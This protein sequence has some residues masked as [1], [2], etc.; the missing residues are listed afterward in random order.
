LN[1]YRIEREPV[2]RGRL[3]DGR[4][5]FYGNIGEG[6]VT[7]GV[8][9]SERAVG[10]PAHEIDAIVKARIAGASKTDIKSLVDRLHAERAKIAEGLFRG[11][12]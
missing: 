8:K 1:E 10:W 9:I 6:L 11:A 4:T 2:A 3:G 12:A 7:R 5:L